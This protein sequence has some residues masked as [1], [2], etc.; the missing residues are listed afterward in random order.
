MRMDRPTDGIRGKGRCS[1]TAA[2]AALLAG[3]A[4]MSCVSAAEAPQR[5]L[6][7]SAHGN[8][9][10]IAQGSGPLVVMLP[11][12]ARGAAD[13]AEVAA[14]LA[15]AGYRVLCVEPRGSGRTEGPYRGIELRDLADDMAGVIRSQHD[16]QAIMVGHAAGSFTARMT[17][18]AYPELVRGVVLA[19]AGAR[20]VASELNRAVQRVHDVDLD[21]AERLRYLQLAF[22]A[23]G[24]D[25]SVWLRGW[26]PLHQFG[27]G[28]PP[29]EA[30]R[31]RWWGAG[32]KPVLEIQGGDDPFK[33]AAVAGEYRAQ[34][35]AR[36]TVTR[37]AH[38]SH[39][40]FPEQPAAVAAAIIDWAGKLPAVTP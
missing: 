13:L 27:N 6:L 23:S 3:L 12:A 22:F 40:L 7:P 25:A 2:A 24:S 33:P 21:E 1:A 10:V 32:A 26:H 19:G 8:V 11:S 20:H 14:L 5:Q 29:D 35:G 4:M 16:G 38:A 37:I 17:A 30:A 34:F 15:A 31:E 39:A 36:V 9:D 18:V 28:G